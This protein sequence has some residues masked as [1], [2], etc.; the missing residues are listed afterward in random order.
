M[1]SGHYCTLF[2]EN[3]GWVLATM[4]N[5]GVMTYAHVCVTAVMVIFYDYVSLTHSLSSE[6]LLA[7][8]LR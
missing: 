2:V 3:R 8:L 6:P 7:L 1:L 4:K 5:C